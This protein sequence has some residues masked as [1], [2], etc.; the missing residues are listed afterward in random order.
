MKIL[1]FLLFFATLS[2]IEEPILFLT[3]K[4]D[5]Q[6]TITAVWITDDP[7]CTGLIEWKLQKDEIFRQKS[8]H[9]TPLEI[10]K[11]IVY[12][13][14]ADLGF[15]KP[16]TFYQFKVEGLEHLHGFKT[17]PETLAEP[18]KFI[19]GGDVY[20]DDIEPV[21]AMMQTAASTNPLFCVL[22]GDLAYSFTSK[23]SEEENLDRW[24]AF[25]SAYS[26]K[27]VTGQGAMIP[28]IP[29]LGNHDIR[30]GYLAGVRNA[31]FFF[32]VFPTPGNLGYATLDFGKWL[33]LF[34]LDSGHANP[35][36]GEQTT[37][38]RKN[39]EEKKGV[40]YIFAI[41]HVGAYPSFRSFT[42]KRA[43]EIRKNWCPLFD[44]YR[45]TAGFEHHD[46]CLKRSVP[47][48]Q[49]VPKEDG[50]IYL[51]DGSFGIGLPRKPYTPNEWWY[52]AHTSQSQAV[53]EVTLTDSEAVFKALS[54]NG[55][56][57]DSTKKPLRNLSK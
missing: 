14:T 32:S 10:N 45:I 2:A 55:Q 46:H 57:L 3:W 27:M 13:L 41:Y 52:L 39:L 49:N 26:K 38:L 16:D 37:W 43:Q 12:F 48:T 22:G 36:S 7:S 19:V 33:T 4:K 35:V 11:Q 40:P 9:K 18:V 47:I 42:S 30:G 1:S 21:V 15:L 6:H 17:A 51:G 23:K 50:V 44:Q 25:L 31:K 20:H 24:Y 8:A 28:L 53:W 54:V 56:I 34:L 5:P 29:V